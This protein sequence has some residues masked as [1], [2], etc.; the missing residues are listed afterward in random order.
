MPLEIS[1]TLSDSDLSHFQKCVDK[2]KSTLEGGHD[3]EAIEAAARQLIKDARTGDLPE[4]I[5]DRIAKLE[6]I[7]N[8]ISDVEWQLAE[9]DRKRVLSALIYFC[10]PEDLIPDHIPGLGFLDDAIYVELVIRELRSEVESYE[11]FSAYRVAEEER[12]KESGLNPHVEREEWLA[13]KR[14]TLHARMR[15]KRTG[16]S[17]TKSWRLSF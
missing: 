2:A 13:D 3:G 11:E 4:F 15:K 14:A 8:M 5:G 17:D 10:N 9:D 1:F 12:R 6:V 16:R 7:I